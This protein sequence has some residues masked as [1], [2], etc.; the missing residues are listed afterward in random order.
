MKRNWRVKMFNQIPKYAFFSDRVVP[1]TDDLRIIGI[2][3]IFTLIIS[4]CLIYFRTGI[5][6][7]N[8]FQEE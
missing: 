5:C 3:G 2:T 1:E 7:S 8:S 6:I 4:Q